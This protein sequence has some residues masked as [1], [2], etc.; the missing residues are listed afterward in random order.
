[1]AKWE[2]ELKEGNQLSRLRAKQMIDLT[3][4]GKITKQI[5]ELTTMVLESITINEK[6][7]CITFLSGNMFACV[8]S[9]RI[10]RYNAKRTL[11]NKAF[12]KL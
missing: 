2:K 6:T 9:C 7:I 12:R 8:E 11:W 4:E 1:M 3:A 5:P 10:G